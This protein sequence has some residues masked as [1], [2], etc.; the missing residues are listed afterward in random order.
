[1]AQSSKSHLS[2]E[3]YH[4]MEVNHLGS[5]LRV[6]RLK[7]GFIFFLGAES[8]FLHIMA[9][10][11]SIGVALNI[12]QFFIKQPDPS[13]VAIIAVTIFGI[14]IAELYA[15]ILLPHQQKRHLI[16]CENGLLEVRKLIR[17]NLVEIVYWAEMV[18]LKSG[19]SF[20]LDY[21]IIHRGKKGVFTLFSSYQHY[22]DLIEVIT[23]RMREAE[24]LPRQ[25]PFEGTD[26]VQDQTK[27]AEQSE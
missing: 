8:L 19:V 15:L 12:R 13:V 1:M 21:H 9:V 10:L 11:L 17:K 5:S 2:E 26:I 16:V 23:E 25:T 22:G 7:P 3:D 20:M 4:L 27:R 24:M 18:E 14:F 6:Y